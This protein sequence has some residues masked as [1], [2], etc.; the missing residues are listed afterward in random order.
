MFFLELLLKYPNKE[1]EIIEGWEML[2]GDTWLSRVKPVILKEA[3]KGTELTEKSKEEATN[4]LNDTSTTPALQGTV[5]Q[6]SD[7][8]KEIKPSNKTTSP[9]SE[10]EQPPVDPNPEKQARNDQ[11]ETVK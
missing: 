3:D 1:T 2:F 10:I 6:E 9:P 11:G 8:N 7:G 5:T 4:K